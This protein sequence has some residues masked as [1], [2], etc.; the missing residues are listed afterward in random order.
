MKETNSYLLLPSAACI[1][2]LEVISSNEFIKLNEL[3][4]EYESP[5]IAYLPEAD[6]WKSG[7]FLWGGSDPSS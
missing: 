6:E 4:E 5:H 3:T 1:L 2:L 7:S